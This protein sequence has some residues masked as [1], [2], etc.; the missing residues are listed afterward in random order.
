MLNFI[1]LVSLI[2]NM[3]RKG[4]ISFFVILQVIVANPTIANSEETTQ[5]EQLNA[6]TG[7]GLTFQNQVL[8]EQDIVLTNKPFTIIENVVLENGARIILISCDN[9]IIRNVTIRSGEDTEPAIT[10]LGS[11]N[12]TITN[13]N[14]FNNNETGIYVDGSNRI[15]ITNNYLFEQM[16]G[17]GLSRSTY[18]LVENNTVQNLERDR[19]IRGNALYFRG[20]KPGAP[21]KAIEH[22]IIRNN[23]FSNTAGMASV[24]GGDVISDYI[25]N[26]NVTIEDNIF[27][28]GGRLTI[29]I[30]Q[31][32]TIRRNQFIPLE[33]DTSTKSTAIEGDYL[34]NLTVSEN[35]ITG[36]SLPVRLHTTQGLVF[37]KNEIYDTRGS[38]GYSFQL[39]DSDD[40][41]IAE[42]RIE[43]AGIGVIIS[44][45]SLDTFIQNFQSIIENNYIKDAEYGISLSGHQSVSI[46]GNTI[47]DVTKGGI[48]V[49]N[50]RNVTVDNNEIRNSLDFGVGVNPG[51]EDLWVRH[52]RFFAV[53]SPIVVVEEP[54]GVFLYENNTADGTLITE[55]VSFNRFSNSSFFTVILIVLPIFEVVRR[56]LRRK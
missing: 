56:R 38:F 5:I 52:N 30:A 14:L 23:L 22:L 13:T 7:H 45:S 25:F 33:T 10:I 46:R 36:R 34:I 53:L 43:N 42:N 32:A 20:N 55:Y 17:I 29:T 1:I 54:Q 24:S 19:D 41:Y 26:S 3:K 16:V 50:S 6:P 21:D 11:T 51:N 37:T 48:T 27:K 47:E 2:L 31:N 12:V 35:F 15:K 39:R 49:S 40:Y 8:N 18:I 44:A 9:S 4:L 28:S